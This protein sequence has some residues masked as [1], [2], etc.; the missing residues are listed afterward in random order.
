M[1]MR[2]TVGEGGQC[3][4]QSHFYLVSDLRGTFERQDLTEIRKTL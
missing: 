1:I 2:T 4:K 3:K